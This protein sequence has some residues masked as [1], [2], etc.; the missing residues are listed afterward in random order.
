MS[1]FVMEQYQPLSMGDTLLRLKV[2]QRR[3]NGNK[4]K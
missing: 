1:D 2:K 3:T 4:V